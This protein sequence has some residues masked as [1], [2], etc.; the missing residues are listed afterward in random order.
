MGGLA[1]KLNEASGW[2]VTLR[3]TPERVEALPG[4]D[5]V[6]TSIAVD[7]DSHVAG[8]PRAGA[9]ARLP[10]RPQRERRPRRPLAHAPLDPADARDREGRR[11]P[12]AQRAC[13]S[14]TP[15]RRT[16][17]ASPST[18]TRSVRSIGLCH[19]VA[20]TIEMVGELLDIPR[21]DVDLRGAG[22][23]HFVWTTSLTERSSGRDLLP[24]LRER[25]AA[26]RSGEVALL[27][28]AL[29]PLRRLPDDGRQ[30]RRRVH[31]L[32]GRVHRHEGLRLRRATAATASWRTP[33]ST[34]GPAGTK[35]VDLAA[36]ASPRASRAS[37]TAAR[38]SWAR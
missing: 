21:D 18:A 32:R 12:R 24:Q 25:A 36:R 20:E 33:T 34:P 31:R 19:G 22:T 30:P 9:E 10:Q 26:R 11:A 14:T 27:L 2:D 29:R 15:T 37:A 5:Y 8:G 6:I 23:N 1:E 17:S 38:R 4:A 16:A 3:T 13:C 7:R 28:V 35:P